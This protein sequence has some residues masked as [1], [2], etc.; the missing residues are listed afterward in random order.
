MAVAAATAPMPTDRVHSHSAS[1]RAGDQ[2]HAERVWLTISKPLTS[3][4]CPHAQSFR[5][6]C[7]A[8]RA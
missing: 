5:N 4:I 3:R 7:I 2:R 1:N 6:S 8:E